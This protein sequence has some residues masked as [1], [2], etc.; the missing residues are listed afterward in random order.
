M[1]NILTPDTIACFAEHLQ[2][3]KKMPNTVGKYRRDTI[4]FMQFLGGLPVTKESVIQYKKHLLDENY[5][6]RSINS[7]LASVNAL[8]SFLGW[9]QCRVRGLKIQHMGYCP[10]EK[11]TDKGRIRA[12]CAGGAA[13]KQPTAGTAAGNNLRNWNPNQ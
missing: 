7:M 4:R 1:E 6:A 13:A 9:E 2:S 3:S 12:T 8:L 11:R 10:E 5:S